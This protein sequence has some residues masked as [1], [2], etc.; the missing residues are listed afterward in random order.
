MGDVIYTDHLLCTMCGEV[1]A[2]E[3]RVVLGGASVIVRYCDLCKLATEQA[4]RDEQADR[5][6]KARGFTPYPDYR[7][8]PLSN[9]TE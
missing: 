3:S 1:W 6:H 8:F 7:D 2:R 5:E 9:A 4:E